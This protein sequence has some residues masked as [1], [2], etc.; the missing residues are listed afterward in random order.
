[1]K[2]C[3][4]NLG[5]YNEGKLLWHWLELPAT[6]E[7]INEAL[8][9]IRVCNE[10]NKYYDCFGQPYEEYHIPD[11]EDFPFDYSEYW[12]INT[13]NKLAEQ[14]EQLD[15]YQKEAFEYFNNNGYSEEEALDKALTG[16]YY[17][18]QADNDT[19]LGENYINEVYGGVEQL[20]AK[21]LAQYFDFEAFGRDLSF[22]FYQ[23]S[24]GYISA[25]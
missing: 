1:M 11:V 6:Q 22:D 5:L 18:I 23:T 24:N 9:K 7:E 4:Q 3:I 13:L 2:I 8:D 15:S 12:N 19:E 16:D 20:D 25:N 14:Y 21:T 17:Y 10:N